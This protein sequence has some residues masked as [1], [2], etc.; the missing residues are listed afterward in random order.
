MCVLQPAQLNYIPSE[1]N[2]ADVGTRV[3]AKN[4]ADS[5]WWKPFFHASSL[6][7]DITESFQMVNPDENVEARPMITTIKVIEKACS[8]LSFSTW[9]KRFCKFSSWEWLVHGVIRLREAAVKKTFYIIPTTV[10]EFR[11]TEQLIVKIAQKGFFEEEIRS[12]TSGNAISEDSTLSSRC[13]YIDVEEVLR[14]GG[15]LKRASFEGKK[16]QGKSNHCS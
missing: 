3:Q 12:L 2:P 7:H 15:R 8:S 4:L 5:R 13:P 10:K 16:K 9:E 1:Q 6:D 11:A 14:I